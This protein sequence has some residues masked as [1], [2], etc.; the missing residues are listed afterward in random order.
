MI[1][2]INNGRTTTPIY[3]PQ[4]VVTTNHGVLEQS[5][6][7]AQNNEPTLAT[8]IV[9]GVVLIFLITFVVYF[10]KLLKYFG[11]EE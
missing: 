6:T 5:N 11:G 7:N 10:I 9:L 3:I 2:P 1:I 8:W 4:P